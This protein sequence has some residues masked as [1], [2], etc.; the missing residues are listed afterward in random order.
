MGKHTERCKLTV[1]AV[2]ISSA[3]V[4]CASEPPKLVTVVV[5]EKVE[6]KT[7]VKKESLIL[8]AKTN[9]NKIKPIDTIAEAPTINATKTKAVELIKPIDTIVNSPKEI[10]VAKAPVVEVKVS[11]VKAP[12]A[13]AAK[14]SNILPVVSPSTMPVKQIPVLKI[15]HNENYIDAISRWVRDSG[16]KQVSWSLSEEVMEK[17]NKRSVGDKNLKPS[18]FASVASISNE[19]QTIIRVHYSVSNGKKIAAIVPWLGES[20]ITIIDA[21]TLKGA[22]EQ[23]ANA[24]GWNF[25]KD[26]QRGK[27]YLA[28]NDK[29]FPAAFPIATPKHDFEMAIDLLIKDYPVISGLYDDTQTVYIMDEK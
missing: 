29:P 24:Y 15:N 13:I 28:V 10:S 11:V 9:I 14:A 26:D 2:L 1:L 12:V 3:M 18:L 8:P 17:L 27:S 19:L 23:L 5:N 20:R 7:V 16:A 25:I 21:P 22:V 4:G 6:V